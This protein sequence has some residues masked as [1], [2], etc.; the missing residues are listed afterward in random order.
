MV[1]FV[2]FSNSIASRPMEL[3][4]FYAASM[5]VFTDRTFISLMLMLILMLTKVYTCSDQ[6]Y[7]ADCYITIVYNSIQ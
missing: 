1:T 5:I 4:D 3:D 2:L 7:K 6:S